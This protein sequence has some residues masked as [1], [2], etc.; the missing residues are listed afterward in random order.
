MIRDFIASDAPA[1]VALQRRLNPDWPVDEASLLN[2]FERQPP[3]AEWRMWVTDSGYAMARRLWEV[4]PAGG[5]YVWAGVAP[6]RRRRGIGSALLATALAHAA[7]L[8]VDRVQTWCRP[9]SAEFLE[10]RGWVRAR[11]R[12]I[13]A[14]GRG[15]VAMPAAPDGIEL[16][17]LAAVDLH[18]LYDLDAVAAVGEPGEEI[19]FGSFDDYVSNEIRRPLLDLDGSFAAL[20]DGLP[21]AFSMIFRRGAVAHNGFTCT[22]PEWRGRGLA[23]LVKSATLRFAFEHGVERVTTM[24]DS[25]NPAMLLVNE[26]LGYRP[27]RVEP[28]L[29]LSGSA[30]AGASA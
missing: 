22:H 18:D 3:A 30:L 4:T 11:E 29:V 20:A 14:V 19:D 15:A 28:Q 12:V 17:P 25:E 24:N 2:D 21:V 1:V 9:E 26:R 5:A 16:V 23:T 10:R 6:E 27:V 8:G 13:S 7:G